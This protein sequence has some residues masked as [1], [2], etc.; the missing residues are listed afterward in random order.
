M[1]PLS[2]GRRHDALRHWQGQG[3]GPGEGQRGALSGNGDCV[4]YGEYGHSGWF[5]GDGG[6]QAI[7]RTF[8]APHHVPS[9]RALRGAR[10]KGSSGEVLVGSRRAWRAGQGPAQGAPATSEGSLLTRAITH[11]T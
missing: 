10:G 4:F 5:E 1:F 7:K 8:P 9:C 11:T 3:E 6:A 2:L